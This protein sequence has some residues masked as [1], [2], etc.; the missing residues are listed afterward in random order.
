MKRSYRFTAALAALALAAG[1]T[2]PAFAAGEVTKDENVFIILN[3]DG[4]VKARP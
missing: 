4:S 1:C 3:A 2:L